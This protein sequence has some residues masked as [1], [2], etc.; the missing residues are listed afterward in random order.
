[1]SQ[2][3]AVTQLTAASRST[4]GCKVAA[5]A[6]CLSD[7]QTGVLQWLYTLKLCQ[8]QRSPQPTYMVLIQPVQC[9]HAP[10]DAPLPVSDN[11]HR[12][13]VKRTKVVGQSDVGHKTEAATTKAVTEAVAMFVKETPCAGGPWRP[14]TCRE[15]NTLGHTV[16]PSCWDHLE[17]SGT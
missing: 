5:Q 3:M 8:F 16:R 12:C 2:L 17:V 1:M 9:L 4:A 15:H 10:G 7:S 14:V 11:I 13:Q 6:A